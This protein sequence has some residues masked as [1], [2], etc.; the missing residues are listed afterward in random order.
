MNQFF[1]EKSSEQIKNTYLSSEK[2][3]MRE[4]LPQLTL[5]AFTTF[6]L[7]N[8]PRQVGFRIARHKF[9]AKMGFL[10]SSPTS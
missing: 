5:P 6:G 10:H 3:V 7:L 9:V 1:G 2:V 4:H 8:D